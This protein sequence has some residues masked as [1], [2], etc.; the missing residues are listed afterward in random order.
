MVKECKHCGIDFNTRSPRKAQ[1]GGKIN[2]CPDCVE[3]LGTE[4]GPVSRGVSAGDGKQGMVTIMRFE[5]KQQGDEYM[6]M[7]KQSTGFHRGKA[8]QMGQTC[9][10]SMDN[11]GQKVGE[12]GGNGNHKGQK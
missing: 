12:H 10:T 5:N 1:V 2:E 8:C 3:E 7:W 4:S 11:M 6:R 9:M